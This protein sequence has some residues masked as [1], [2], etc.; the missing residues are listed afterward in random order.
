MLAISKALLA[1]G[2]GLLFGGT[3]SVVPEQGT[4]VTGCLAKGPAKDTLDLKGNDGKEY[5][6]TSDSVKLAPHVGHTVTLEG[7]AAAPDAP[8]TVTK[9]TMVS[10]KCKKG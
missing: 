8:L 7:T 5:R 6:V 2:G 10:A 9:L 4:T 3:A 1:L